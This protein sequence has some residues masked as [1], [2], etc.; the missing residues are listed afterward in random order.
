M[1]R[2]NL[3]LQPHAP[4]KN[5]SLSFSVIQDLNATAL[6]PSCA[7]KFGCYI[8]GMVCCHRISVSLV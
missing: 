3:W 7:I 2:E 1:C 4:R 6:S 8:Y 5:Y